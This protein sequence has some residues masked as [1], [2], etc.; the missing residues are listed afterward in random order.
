[1]GSMG[2]KGHHAPQQAGTLEMYDKCYSTKDNR[3]K[4]KFC[5]CCEFREF[6]IVKIS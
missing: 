1:M 4:V 2:I 3:S 5:K 6:K